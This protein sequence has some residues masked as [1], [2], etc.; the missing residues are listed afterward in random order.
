[1]S[2]YGFDLDGTLAKHEPGQGVG[3]VGEPV[4][5]MVAELRRHLMAGHECRIMTA[6]VSCRNEREVAQQTEII[7]AWLEAQGLPRLR[8]TCCKDYAMVALYDDR[9]IQVV[10]ND[11]RVFMHPDWPFEGR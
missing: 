7:H 5:L 8:V 10:P 1:M 4:L 11:G 9:A 2:W 6:R 3:R